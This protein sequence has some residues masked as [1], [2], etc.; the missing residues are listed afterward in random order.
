MPY[1]NK[2]FVSFDGDT[3]IHY[4]RLMCA[5]KRND[6]IS[7]NF[8]DAHD[9][10]TA[11]DTSQEA[12]IKRKL[13]TRL[14]NAKIVVSLIGEHTRYLYKF[15]RWELEQSIDLD[16][17]IVA[18]NLNGHRF[19]DRNRCPPIIR[20]RSVIHIGFGSRILQ[21]ALDHWPARFAQLKQQGVDEPHYYA[22][23]VYSRLGL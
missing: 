11:R 14:S 18:V 4:Y 6:N 22:D 2:T 23:D 5:W 17:P 19:V 10:N 20:D 21:Y 15:V 13:R 16:L 7:F 8:I 1:R 12:T 9:L 3:D